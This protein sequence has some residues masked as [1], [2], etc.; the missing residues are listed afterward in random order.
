M[1]TI[2]EA[3]R[4]IATRGI[5]FINTGDSNERKTHGMYVPMVSKC[6]H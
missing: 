1:M 6:F 2:M 4:I 3:T 5:Y